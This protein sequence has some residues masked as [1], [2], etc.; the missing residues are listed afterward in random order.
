[1]EI[2]FVHQNHRLTRR[3]CDEVAHFILWGNAGRGIVRIAHV[4]E[5]FLRSIHH[6]W[7]IMTECG[8]ERNFHDLSAVGGRVINDCFESRI[9]HHQCT[10]LRS[11]ECLRAQIQNFARAVAQ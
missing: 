1:M 5:S 9:A 10:L 4:N 11:G 7:K 2:S 6:L 3:F 8:G